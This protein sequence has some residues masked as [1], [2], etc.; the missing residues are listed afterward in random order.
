MSLAGIHLLFISLTTLLAVGTGVFGLREWFADDSTL[1]LVY[2][3][4]SLVA[5]PFLLVYGVRV[6]RKLK[7]LGAFSG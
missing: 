2:G 3:V 4:L 7:E 6:R 5:I 1:G